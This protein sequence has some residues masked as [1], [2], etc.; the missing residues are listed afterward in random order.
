MLP[1]KDNI[2]EI[3][4]RQIDTIYRVCYT[5]LGQPQEA[6]DI[7]QTV[8]VKLLESGK[9]FADLE[10]EKAW[11]ITTA[12]NACYD[13]L[14]AQQRRA[15]SSLQD[16]AYDPPDPHAH[17][18][19]EQA[20]IEALLAHLPP[21]DRFMLYLYYYEGYKQEEIARMMDLNLNTLKTRLRAAR[22]K[23]KLELEEHAHE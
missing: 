7:V 9:I 1:M 5:M 18:L 21:Q 22:T 20:A 11:L 10:H 23:L 3:Y 6:E 19:D 8:F 12:R 13:R 15:T 4:D 17:R 14:R 2:L 16:L